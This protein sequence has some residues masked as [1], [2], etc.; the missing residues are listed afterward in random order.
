M[1][2]MK[3]GGKLNVFFVVAVL[4]LALFVSDSEAFPR[5]HGAGQTSVVKEERPPFFLKRASSERGSTE[6]SE[7][8][9]LFLHSF[10][11]A[12]FKDPKSP[13]A[14]GVGTFRVLNDILLGPSSC[15]PP[16]GFAAFNIFVLVLEGSVEMGFRDDLLLPFQNATLGDG[17]VLGLRSGAYVDTFLCNNDPKQSAHFLFL[18]FYPLRQH[19]HLLFSFEVL[20][21]D[22]QSLP[23]RPCLLASPETVSI[24]ESTQTDAASPLSGC[25]DKLLL[26]DQESIFL[27]SLPSS[28]LERDS[29][30]QINCSKRYYLHLSQVKKPEENL[31][32]SPTIEIRVKDQGQ[33]VLCR[34]VE[35]NFCF[36]IKSRSSCFP[37]LPLISKGTL[38]S[39]SIVPRDTTSIFLKSRNQKKT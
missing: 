34:D 27:L 32:S 17:D 7:N 12:S 22:Q 4:V 35:T 38:P 15:L 13:I 8:N 18:W 9:A 28:D 29:S 33:P 39:K 20:P 24:E 26:S 19:S 21:L 3:G 30:F 11:Y 37:C 31:T 1:E 23:N 36:L 6:Y 25:G 10:E 14:Q 16:K 2:K 5:G